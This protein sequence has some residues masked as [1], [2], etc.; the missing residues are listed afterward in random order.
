MQTRVYIETTIPS[1]FYTERTDAKSI[2]RSQWT[3]QWWD[4]YSTRFKLFSSPAVINELRRGSHT[5]VQDR[6]SLLKDVELLEATDEVQEIVD[7]Y[8]A[9][10]VMPRDPLGDALHMALTTF[11]RLDVLLTWNCLHLANPNKMEHLRL[12]N[13]EIGFPTPLVTTP[14]SYLSGD[15]SNG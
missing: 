13:Y 1:S 2:A 10:Q 5:I 9:K 4:D 7:I 8:I 6:I 15:E 14:F 11:N 12:I 3:R